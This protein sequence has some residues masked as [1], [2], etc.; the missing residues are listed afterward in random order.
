MFCTTI[1]WYCDTINW[2]CDTIMRVKSYNSFFQIQ[3]L[4]F[5]GCSFSPEP[6]YLRNQSPDSAVLP[7]EFQRHLLNTTLIAKNCKNLTII[8]HPS[9]I[10]PTDHAIS[11]YHTCVCNPCKTC[12]PTK[13]T[14]KS[15]RIFLNKIKYLDFFM[16]CLLITNNKK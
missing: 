6:L 8:S 4:T 10:T 5:R 9:I 15:W 7:T 12:T 11:K 3:D 14:T 1:N 13:T 2:Y 16:Q